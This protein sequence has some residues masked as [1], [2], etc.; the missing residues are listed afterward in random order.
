MLKDITKD[1]FCAR[2]GGDEFICI[3]TGVDAEEVHR[4][5]LQ[6]QETLCHLNLEHKENTPYGRVTVSQGY[7]VRVPE[8][9]DDFAL[10]LKE[11]DSGLYKSKEK[12]RN[13][14]TAAEI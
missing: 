11:A 5:S 13:C 10:F 9:G 7:S 14:T 2:Y 8:A 6:I 4:I 12:G 1:H 3:F